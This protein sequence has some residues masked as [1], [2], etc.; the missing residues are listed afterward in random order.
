MARSRDFSIFLL[1]DD[2][3]AT[4]ALKDD[5]KLIEAVPATRL[6]SE[7]SLFVLDGQPRAPWWKTYFG[8]DRELWQASKGALVFLPVADR[9]CVLA[10]GHVSHNL[11]DESYEYDF[12]IRVTLNCVDPTKLKNT[13]TLE[14]GSARRQRTQH[15]METDL[16]YFD[17]DQDSSVLKSITGKVKAEY[18]DVLKHA[19]G[20]SGLRV[21]TP[22]VSADLIDLCE[23]LLDLYADESY[24]ESFPDIQKIVP[25]RDPTQV[26]RLNRN[27]EKAVRRR[28]DNLQL[29]VPE[30]LDYSRDSDSM[31]AMFEA[32]GQGELYSDVA[33][34]HY[35][36]H[37]TAK[38]IDVR[39]LTI[40][41]LKAHRLKLVNQDGDRRDSHSVFK[42]LLFDTSLSRDS[43]A[44]YLNEGNWYEVDRDY[45]NG[46]QTRLDPFWC[47]L[48]FLEDCSEHLEA[49]YNKE[50]GKKAGYVCLDTTD[51]SRKGQTQVEPCDVYTVID[52]HAVL[53]HVKIS[54]ASSQLSHLFN[55]GTNAVELLRSD[56]ESPD[57]LK[58]LLRAKAKEKDDVGSL[59]APVDAGRYSV[60]FAIITRKDPVRKSLNL[61]L[62]SRISLARNI[63]ALDRL[64]HVPVTFGFIKNIAPPQPVQPKPK[65][66]RTPRGGSDKP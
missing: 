28:A 45:V 4:T 11:R 53:V 42:S 66:A 24:I 9:V 21:S 13:D 7:A 32:G 35:Y 3:D 34:V 63:R 54:T 40:E 5:H 46:L 49:D 50:I 25:V 64:M 20:G 15:A 65:K 37:L 33:I 56:D 47:D 60:V 51:V 12:G 8:V 26:S 1:K 17:F 27:L 61:P 58:E 10:F 52:D 22:V 23:R 36:D 30:M 55:Q 2:Y 19:T 38:G 44:Y 39:T 18:A 14:P 16:T 48:T 59:T 31:Y 43:A 29:A 62:F 57:K 6:P 41:Q